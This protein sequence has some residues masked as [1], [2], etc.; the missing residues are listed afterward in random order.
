MPAPRSEFAWCVKLVCL[1]DPGLRA[2]HLAPRVATLRRTFAR[3]RRR[4]SLASIATRRKRSEEVR[5]HDHILI[6]EFLFSNRTWWTRAFAVSSWREYSMADFVGR[7][8]AKRSRRSR[9]LR[10][11]TSSG[12][13]LSVHVPSQSARTQ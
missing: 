13:A 11:L 6:G 10:G 4:G 12:R 5:H 1:L 2:P 3:F 8:R 7:W 9:L